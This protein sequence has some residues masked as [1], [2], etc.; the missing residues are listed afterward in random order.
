MNQNYIINISPEGM[1]CR[2]DQEKTKLVYLNPPFNLDKEPESYFSRF[3]SIVSHSRRLLR[4]DGFLAINVSHRYRAEYQ[5]IL[6]QHFGKKNFKTEIIIPHRSNLSTSLYPAHTTILLFS[7]S[8]FSV[9]NDVYEPLG[10]SEVSRYKN[11][12]NDPN[13]P[14]LKIVLTIPDKFYR[15]TNEFKGIIPKV[16]HSWRYTNE[17]LEKLSK[18]NRLLFKN[19]NVYLKK[20]LS[21]SP[22]KKITSVWE[23]KLSSTALLSRLILATTDK[24][25]LVVDPYCG[26]GSSLIAAEE[27]G[28]LW[29]GGDESK[30]AIELAI[31]SYYKV[32][33]QD[34]LERITDRKFNHLFPNI[35]IYDH[36]LV[37]KTLPFS[38]TH[39]QT[40]KRSVSSIS[41]NRTL[42]VIVSLE[43]Y[44]PREV[45]SI[46]PVKYA[47]RD[48]SLF[49]TT[50]IKN[51]GVI[52][53]DIVVF[54]NENAL[55]NDLEYDL[56]GLINA[57]T[58]N[59]RFIFYYVGH[60]FHDGTSNYLTTYCTHPANLSETTISLDDLLID[61]IKK[62]KCKSALFFI[63]ACAKNIKNKNSR[64]MIQDLLIEEFEILN[65]T[66]QHFA[67]F[68][69][70]SSGQSS[71]SCDKLKNGVWTHHLNNAISGSKS[72]LLIDNKYLT[73]RS[74]SDYLSENVSKY[75]S[76][77]L[78]YQQ[79]PRSILDANLECVLIDIER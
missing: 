53:E 41:F 76:E 40:K 23:D 24:N 27:T 13:G 36:K 6:E 72:E 56:S 34:N 62:S 2:L 79:S 3:S 20:Y 16:G 38:N 31:S 69:S 63:D 42:V 35:R 22:G 74:L 75:V 21:E 12:D 26:N 44:K 33:N 65:S 67:T 49:R 19:G 64:N 48:A 7:K 29:F 10:K 25:D 18:E 77:N 60:G 59:D 45:N 47:N 70:C 61:P 39:V 57:L 32:I 52:E 17:R 71:Y 4:E 28:R 58:E 73:D 78:N 14:Y 68:L 9:I 37:L 55:R 11:V 66:N 8:R 54:K 46:M 50:L 1:V 51:W 15:N 30:K 5:W 43:D